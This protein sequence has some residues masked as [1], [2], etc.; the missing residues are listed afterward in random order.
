MLTCY[1]LSILFRMSQE[2]SASV[3]EEVTPSWS[4]IDGII[5]D[6]Y[7]SDSDPPAEPAVPTQST[8]DTLIQQ[9]LSPSGSPLISY[10]SQPQFVEKDPD[11]SFGSD[12]RP[13]SSLPARMMSEAMS[14]PPR[15]SSSASFGSSQRDRIANLRRELLQEEERVM[16]RSEDLDEL[17]NHARSALL[18]EEHPPSLP[19]VSLGLDSSQ[20][21]SHSILE[22]QS[23]T[24]LKLAKP[25]STE[26]SEVEDVLKSVSIDMTPLT[27]DLLLNSRV[28]NAA[29][30]D[31]GQTIS[32]GQFP[33]DDEIVFTPLSDDDYDF[34]KAFTT[35]PQVV[36]KFD[37]KIKKP[38]PKRGTNFVQIQTNGKII[39]NT[40]LGSFDETTS[41]LS[42]LDK[43]PALSKLKESVQPLRRHAWSDSE[44]DNTLSKSL[45]RTQLE[46]LKI[47]HKLPTHS[48]KVSTDFKSPEPKTEF[49]IP[50]KKAE[51]KLSDSKA[52][53]TRPRSAF[54]VL[55]P[56][57]GRYR[58]FT[59]PSSEKV[60]KFD[61][62][63]LLTNR[64]VSE[65]D[66][67]EKKT[68]DTSFDSAEYPNL[69]N[70][71]MSLQNTIMTDIAALRR[72]IVEKQEGTEK[73]KSEFSDFKHAYYQ[74]LLEN[75]TRAKSLQDANIQTSQLQVEEKENTS[76]YHVPVSQNPLAD[77]QDTSYSECD[78]ETD[79][80]LATLTALKRSLREQTNERFLR[81]MEQ[82]IDG[83]KT[84]DTSPAPPPPVPPQE[85]IEPRVNGI[86]SVTKVD[87]MQ[88]SSPAHVFNRSIQTAPAKPTVTVD[89]H[90][91]TSDIDPSRSPARRT[92]S[93]PPRPKTSRGDKAVTV[94]AYTQRTQS[95][96]RVASPVQ[97]PAPR[98]V[99]SGD[100]SL[101]SAQQATRELFMD[102]LRKKA[103][104]DEEERK[105]KRFENKT[106]E[107]PTSTP[108]PEGERYRGKSA[109]TPASILSEDSTLTD[110][111]FV[112]E[113]DMAAINALWEQFMKFAV[114]SKALKQRKPKSSS[115]RRP[116]IE[117]DV[118][119][120]ENLQKSFSQETFRRDKDKAEKTVNRRR[121]N[122]PKKNEKKVVKSP[123]QFEVSAEEL[124]GGKTR[125]QTAPL[126]SSNRSIDSRE[127]RINRLII[128][129]FILNNL[130]NV[131]I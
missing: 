39:G 12:Y 57:E 112:A 7:K 10:Y 53:E 65:P 16:T 37:D 49:K 125:P 38:T 94:D 55:S 126:D 35:P 97:P 1:H 80:Q 66:R 103:E 61:I 26:D 63:H 31:G 3:L 34:S 93:P 99:A 100:S 122:S 72:E 36:R 121:G 118:K 83:R 60:D 120:L 114:E 105:N 101:D 108:K 58:P 46:D 84:A 42:I 89:V 111:T 70:S 13:I 78:S 5:S 131:Y 23:R 43:E 59:A 69:K 64:F 52:E 87:R 107:Q 8:Q 113:Q 88:Q 130:N 71:F 123:E 29:S 20:Q 96:N 116:C 95:P 115:R 124:K 73:L 90:C 2:P 110:G 21:M 14:T 75:Q 48:E 56:H 79:R 17:R 117:V 51:F 74:S 54:A 76:S 18:D 109:F 28:E 11:F 40:E 9:P 27:E 81:D 25:S 33:N 44:T 104:D 91:N 6:K 41:S 85:P 45:N 47:N 50:E 82:R 106:K 24:R 30:D 127:E 92:E 98:R 128:E 129:V 86:P 22:E 102:I 19:Q 32:D 4:E 62:P 119:K 15:V 67:L 68:S 77:Q